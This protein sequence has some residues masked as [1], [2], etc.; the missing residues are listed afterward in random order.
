MTRT[1]DAAVYWHLRAICA[2]TQRYEVIARQAHTDLVAANKR[3]TQALAA[4]GFDPTM[5]SFTLDDDSCAI[6]VPDPP[7]P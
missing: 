4:L 7:G 6:T 2:E 1:L 5:P 3:Q